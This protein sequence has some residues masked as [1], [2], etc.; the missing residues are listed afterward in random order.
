MQSDQ[1]AILQS[2]C[3]SLSLFKNSAEKRAL[4]VQNRADELETKIQTMSDKMQEV[5][6]LIYSR[7]I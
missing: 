3:E 2:E 4:A 6:L 1:L 5:Y 7:A